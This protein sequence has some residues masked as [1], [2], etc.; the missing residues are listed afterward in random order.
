MRYR[1]TMAYLMIVCI[2]FEIGRASIGLL[3]DGCCSKFI[4]ILFMGLDW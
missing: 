3:L 1:F 2:Y 4:V